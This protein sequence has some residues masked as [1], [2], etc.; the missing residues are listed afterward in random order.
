MSLDGGSKEL[1][2]EIA[3]AADPYSLIRE[4]RRLVALEVRIGKFVHVSSQNRCNKR[5][6][7]RL[8]LYKYKKLF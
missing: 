1:Y 3:F 4:L 2:L 5:L 7:A 8:L 6:I